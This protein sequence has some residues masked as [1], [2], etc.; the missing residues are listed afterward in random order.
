MKADSEQ[1][2]TNNHPRI[3]IAGMGLVSP[4]GLSAWDSFRALLDGRT[5]PDRLAELPTNIAPVDLVQ[6]VGSACVAQ[7]SQYDPSLELAERA[8]REATTEA[9]IPLKNMP[10]YVATSKGA[11]HALA[12]ATASHYDGLMLSNKKQYPSA[13]CI[14]S[15]AAPDPTL[16]DYPLAVA[17]GPQQYLNYHLA[18]RLHIQ[19][20]SHTVAACASSLTAMHLARSE[21]QHNSQSPD[22]CM[23]LT[24]E[25]ALIP[26][27]IYSYKRLGVLAKANVDSYCQRP[28]NQ[29]R[30]GF[31]LSEF[32]AAIVLK[33]LK[34]NELPTPGQIELTGTAISASAYDL[35][36]SNPLMPELNHIATKLFKNR[37]IDVI[38]PHATGTPDH[39]PAELAAL[40]AA[41]QA[42]QQDT[43]AHIPAYAIK[44]AVGHGLG[45]AGLVSLITAA[46]S[47]RTGKLPPMPWIDNPLKLDGSPIHIT[48]QPQTISRTGSHAAFAA[49]FGGHT[50]GALIT[51][52]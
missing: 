6:A 18:R 48:P 40:S 32:G 34:P 29:E 52:H 25:A 51:R 4:L 47:L 23:I 20:I 33:R 49:G 38:H 1:I 14:Y 15:A 31:M 8:A 21:L 24:A 41:L 44:G 30:G 5:L 46:L 36:R 10:T 50:A 45:A 2:S 26:Q 42:T 9:N 27:L 16:D 17:M 13:D 28:L 11:V 35:I 37:T 22:H 39:D 19:P 12:R 3:V 7:H 43:S